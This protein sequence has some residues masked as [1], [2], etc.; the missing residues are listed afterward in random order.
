MINALVLDFVTESRLKRHIRHSHT[1]VRA[2]QGGEL[3]SSA[4]PSSG[5]GPG[6]QLHLGG[7]KA[8]AVYMSS[9]T[10]H[11]VELPAERNFDSAASLSPVTG[12]T[13]SG[14]IMTLPS[15]S[16]SPGS[17]INEVPD[18]VEVR[19]GSTLS[20]NEPSEPGHDTPTGT[21]YPTASALPAAPHSPTQLHRLPSGKTL[22]IHVDHSKGRDR[23]HCED[24]DEHDDNEGQSCQCDHSNYGSEGSS[25]GNM[26]DD[27]ESLKMRQRSRLL[28]FTEVLQELGTLRPPQPSPRVRTTFRETVKAPRRLPWTPHWRQHQQQQLPY[29][30]P[31]QGPPG[32]G[33]IGTSTRRMSMPLTP[34]DI[35]LED[36]YASTPASPSSLASGS[37]HPVGGLFANRRP[38]QDYSQ[39][40][41]RVPS[42]AFSFPPWASKGKGVA[43]EN[44]S[45]STEPNVAPRSGAMS[46]CPEGG[47]SSP[48]FEGS[49]RAQV[50]EGR[51][52]EETR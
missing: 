15:P 18:S 16:P 40:L 41:P 31:M 36:F 1:R 49:S 21:V 28:S 45:E 37:N 34:D 50:L 10:T 39:A 43:L 8:A 25:E 2:A 51:E 24:D 32:A 19:S 46:E 48:M 30:K 47:S 3:S 20:Q 5:A 7:G 6:Q 27:G 35:V 44:L 42:S 29:L 13:K 14:E 17:D 4:N 33:Y 22:T 11:S 12:E 52:T 26:S 38:S 9:G 23:P